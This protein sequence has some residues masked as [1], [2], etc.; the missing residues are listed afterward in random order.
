MNELINKI[1][2]SI[3][4]AYFL[5]PILVFLVVK[6]IGSKWFYKKVKDSNG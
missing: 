1:I 4:P 5:V 3:Q 6:L 2:Y